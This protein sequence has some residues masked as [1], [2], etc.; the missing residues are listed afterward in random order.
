MGRLI[1]S[2]TYCSLLALMLAGSVFAQQR[3]TV[4]QTL[5]KNVLTPG[6]YQVSNSIGQFTHTFIVTP[7]NPACSMTQFNAGTGAQVQVSYD[8]SQWFTIARSLISLNFNSA[9]TSASA[10]TYVVNGSYPYVRLNLLSLPPDL[11]TNVGNCTGASIYYT[12][13][14]DSYNQ[15]NV[16]INQYTQQTVGT[17]CTALA[18]FSNSATSSSMLA[19]TGASATT[20]SGTPTKVTIYTTSACTGR[21]VVV[22]VNQPM[23]PDRFNTALIS[24]T[25]NANP[26]SYYAIAD[27]GTA[28]LGY[29]LAWLQ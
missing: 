23:L 20:A 8:N 7:T 6:I 25:P 15:A 11:V 2:L 10:K 4:Y 17:T 9:N 1:K 26:W 22:N 27:S 13:T 24:M 14:F 19:I 5:G 21:N 16:N 3:N 18:G 12:G 29:Y 28:N